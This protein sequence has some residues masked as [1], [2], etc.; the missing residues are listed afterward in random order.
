MIIII[1]FVLTF[2]VKIV[3]TIPSAGE[4][5]DREDYISIITTNKLLYNMTKEIT[6]DKNNLEYMF[7]T[8][9]EGWNFKYTKDS[10]NNVDKKDLF[11]YTGANFEPWA[12]EFI[13]EL[14]KN[15]VGVVNGSRG[16]KITYLN[17]P[18]KYGDKEIK[19]NPYY[20]M[21]FEEYKISLYNIKNSIQERDP[22]NR[23]FYEEN[24]TKSI[25]EAEEAYKS[26]KDTLAEA[27]DYTFLVEGDNLD[28]FI[29]NVGIK[30]I[31]LSGYGT[32]PTE[33]EKL[34]KKLKDNKYFIFLYE[35]EEQLKKY[36][37]LIKKYNI[38]AVPIIKYKQ[39]LDYKGIWKEN[40]KNFKALIGNLNKN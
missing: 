34:E 21:G 30:N 12:D 8:E 28:Y 11:I 38:N 18:I 29:K 25:K 27:K 36:E 22:K 16:I 19:E 32:S 10:L 40:E 33:D 5:T 35:N 15:K 23:D 31:K 14:K 2:K 3:N 20:W 7:K 39:N 24:F 26:F 37:V 13:G 1:S 9:E 4:I 6:K 17:L